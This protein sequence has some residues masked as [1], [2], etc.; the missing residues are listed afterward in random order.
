M[1]HTTHV[2][3]DGTKYSTYE[4]LSTKKFRPV[5]LGT[6]TFCRDERVFFHGQPTSPTNNTTM[7]TPA[8]G[9]T[10]ET[11]M[12]P[13]TIIEIRTE[14][15]EFAGPCES[16]ISQ[17]GIIVVE[18]GFKLAN[19]S[20]AL[21]YL[22]TD[23]RKAHA[24]EYMQHHREVMQE[25]A[26]EAATGEKEYVSVDIKS[27]HI[28]TTDHNTGIFEMHVQAA[29]LSVLLW[30]GFIMMIAGATSGNVPVLV[31]GIVLLVLF[32]F[33]LVS[34]CM[35]S[36]YE[37]T[38]KM[39]IVGIAAGLPVGIFAYLIFGIFG[40]LCWIAKCKFKEKDSCKHYKNA[41]CFMFA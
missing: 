16:C 1:F 20:K 6:D 18:L 24:D 33:L 5:T 35:T 28:H 17:G 38:I 27:V 2:C 13:G 9:D 10:I 40:T 11:Q 31:T 39:Q 25:I 7:S 12:G 29:I 26:A 3:M 19:Q 32:F 23:E 37:E 30:V 22:S 15:I 8:I 14:E 21:L 36:K 41:A 34:I 4:V